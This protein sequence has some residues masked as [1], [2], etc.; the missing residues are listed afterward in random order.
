MLHVLGTSVKI[1]VKLQ[2]VLGLQNKSTWRDAV[3]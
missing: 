1:F 2:V 3:G